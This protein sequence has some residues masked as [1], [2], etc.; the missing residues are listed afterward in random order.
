MQNPI[1]SIKT[2]LKNSSNNQNTDQERVEFAKKFNNILPDEF[3][4]SALFAEP[5][6]SSIF[7]SVGIWIILAVQII[8]VIILIVKK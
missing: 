1:D 5:Q 8:T 3:D 6:D 4:F 2:A 7:G